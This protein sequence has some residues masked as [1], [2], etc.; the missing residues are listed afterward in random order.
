[1]AATDKE[2]FWD[3]TDDQKLEI[4]NEIS[5][6]FK[7]DPKAAEKDWWVCHVIHALFS[8]RCAEAL[9]FKGG[10]SLSKAW[11]ITERFSE[12]VDV[13]FDKSFFGLTVHPATAS[14]SSP[15]STF[16]MSYG[17]SF[18]PPSGC[19]GPSSVKLFSVAGKIPTQTQ[20]CCW[21]PT[22]ACCLHIRILR[23][24]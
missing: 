7:I 20:L 3:Y 15:E 4:Y 23:R 19:S 2:Y 17:K 11:G 13:S 24:R 12:D 14:A 8:L 9:T 21:C 6:Q 22:T 16:T 5:Q 18:H 1:M 10:T